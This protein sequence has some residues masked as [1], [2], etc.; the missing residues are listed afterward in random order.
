MRYSVLAACSVLCAWAM[1]AC[2]G[3]TASTA[4]K[5]NGSASNLSASCVVNATSTIYSV[6]SLVDATFVQNG[7]TLLGTLD[8]PSESIVQSPLSGEVSGSSIQ[9][10]TVGDNMISFTGTV[11]AMSSAGYSI[12]GT[13]SYPSIPD[14]GTFLGTCKFSANG[15]A[16]T[17][18]GTLTEAAPLT[19]GTPS[20]GDSET[21][22]G[23]WNEG[24]DAGS[25]WTFDSGLG[26]DAGLFDSGSEADVKVSVD[27]G[28]VACARV[29]LVSTTSPFDISLHG[30]TLFVADGDAGLK[31]V[32]VTSDFGPRVVGSIPTYLGSTIGVAADPS[33]DYVYAFD[34]AAGL[35]VVD[36]SNSSKPTVAGHVLIPGLD[37]SIPPS[38]GTGGIAISGTSVYIGGTFT[39]GLCTVDVSTP[40]SPTVIGCSTSYSSWAGNFAVSGNFLFATSGFEAL[41]FND[42]NAG[43]PLLL[44]Q[45]PSSGSSGFV[46]GSLGIL[47]NLVL[48]A[49]SPGGV[50]SVS[51]LGVP[52]LVANLAISGP[53]AAAISGRFGLIADGSQLD[54]V[55]LDD[56][57]RP[58]VA[59]S[60]KASEYARSNSR[61]IATSTEAYLVTES[62]ISVW[63]L[64]PDQLPYV[65]DA[66]GPDGSSA[67]DAGADVGADFSVDATPDGF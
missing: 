46:S 6:T 13:Y 12:S 21:D 51:N 23:D 7:S 36:S 17:D 18:G 29:A 43:G 54:F 3:S 1:S 58:F 40:T 67:V 2:S 33:S 11:S 24:Y 15:G 34:D 35:I 50:L 62:G 56:P 47:G 39:T 52:T 8:I 5:S 64:F 65:A 16:V 32:D 60:C 66:G 44:E 37:S 63:Q 57:S 30:K 27:A 20:N 42:Q 61:L 41:V 55:S 45:Y 9:F 10:G 4:S 53:V 19:N 48:F 59:A 25:A 38:L 28:S 49:G 31:V 22:S 26:S 14:Q